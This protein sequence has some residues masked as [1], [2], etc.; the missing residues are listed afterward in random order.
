M[1]TC[2]GALWPAANT[3]LDAIT[4]PK[5]DAVSA[6]AAR[7]LLQAKI[8]VRM[9]T[10]DAALTNKWIPIPDSPG[11]AGSTGYIAGQAVLDPLIAAVKAYA[12]RKGWT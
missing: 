1:V 3:D 7:P 11:V 8:D 6:A 2:I 12:A 4:I 10:L 9:A 5:A